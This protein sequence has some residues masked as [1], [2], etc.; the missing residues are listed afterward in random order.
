MVNIDYKKWQEISLASF[1][2]FKKLPNASAYGVEGDEYI[3]IDNG[4][5][6]LAVC[7]L[8]SVVMPD[9]ADHFYLLTISGRRFVFNAQN[10]DRAGAYII[11]DLLPKLFGEKSFDYLLCDNEESGAT[12]ARNFNRDV[13]DGVL[14]FK[15]RYNW[16]VEFD[17]KGDDAVTYSYMATE[18]RDRLKGAGFKLGNGSFS[19]ISALQNLGCCGVNVGVGYND[20]HSPF[21]R[22]DVEMMLGNLEK[23]K[24]FYDENKDIRYEHTPVVAKTHT[25]M[26]PAGWG[27]VEDWGEYYGGY[28]YK[29][30]LPKFVSPGSKRPNNFD[31]IKDRDQVLVVRKTLPGTNGT[32]VDSYVYSGPG[33]DNIPINKAT[34]YRCSVCHRYTWAEDSSIVYGNIRCRSCSNI[35]FPGTDTIIP[36][37]DLI[38]ADEGGIVVYSEAANDV[39]FDVFPDDRDNVYVCCSCGRFEWNKYKFHLSD[40]ELNFCGYCFNNVGDNDDF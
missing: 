4:A 7:H 3:H 38:W 36:T 18:W 23:F 17:R 19:D 2:Y 9:E 26:Y 34:A 15:D 29:K 31:W 1:D 22:L 30:Y 40:G 33:S 11:L 5:N 13:R 20:Y 24:T 27:D 6:L 37:E 16:M 25:Y 8:D 35:K 21:S 12:T 14:P 28:S 32:Q 39:R 10:D